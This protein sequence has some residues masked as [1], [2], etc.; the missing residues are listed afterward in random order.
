MGAQT[1]ESRSNM[2]S[3]ARRKLDETGN[4]FREAG[5][6]IRVIPRGGWIAAIRESLGMSVQNLADRLGMTRAAAA[7]LE[8]SER[9]QTIQLDTLR[10]A[11]D[12]LECDLVYALVP[13]QP[14]QDLVNSRRLEILKSM[15]QRT[16]QHM[17]LEA[18]DVSDPEYYLHLL[19]QA[20][21]LVPDRML[22]RKR[23]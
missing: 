17:R 5:P 23:T 4:A 2:L 9:S 1:K 10:K 16:Q 6:R 3:I 13:R 20:E 14:L 22:W 7:K 12:A 19:N 11:A 8:V 15:Q 21:F 18:Q